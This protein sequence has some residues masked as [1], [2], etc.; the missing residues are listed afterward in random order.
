MAIYSIFIGHEGQK[1]ESWLFI[2]N[3]RSIISKM[4]GKKVTV[5]ANLKVKHIFA[6]NNYKCSVKDV[7]VHV[8]L[9]RREYTI[10]WT[11]IHDY[12]TSGK[13]GNELIPT[14]LMV[15]ITTK[16]CPFCFN[17]EY[18]N[19]YPKFNIC[20]RTK[21]AIENIPA[22]EVENSL[23]EDEGSSNSGQSSDNE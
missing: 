8:D 19:N 13:F 20:N 3:Y 15:L 17:L 22:N 10:I 2:G 21:E 5:N 23:S 18:K 11:R 14:G 6:C 7:E 16:L 9:H 4:P 1:N 12:D